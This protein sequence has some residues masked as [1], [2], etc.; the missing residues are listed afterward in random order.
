MI[1]QNHWVK[2]KYFRTMSKG[3]RE[4]GLTLVAGM[5]GVGKTVRSCKEIEAY[6][7]ND[8]R[9][10]RIGRKVLIFDVN[11]EP[12]YRK[13][14]TIDYDVEDKDANRRGHWIRTFAESSNVEAR[15]LV[16]FKK[17]GRPFE[18]K[19]FIVCIQDIASNFKKG[20]FVAEDINKYVSHKNQDEILGLLITLR[21]KNLDMII[22]LQ[23][24]SKV[25]TTMWE[26]T[27]Y[28]RMH[29]QSDT[30]DRYKNR[31]PNYQ[32]VKMAELIIDKRYLDG[33]K[34]NPVY[35]S[36]TDNIFYNVTEQEFEYACNRYIFDYD[37][38]IKKLQRVEEGGKR[39]YPT[40]EDAIKAW[41][42]EKRFMIRPF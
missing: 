3:A 7:M 17:N 13:Y 37:G 22:H 16:P 14:L 27:N 34:Y 29:K 41:I 36:P 23:S 11:N 2:N 38:D 15:R 42:N 32:I 10:G 30:V 31:I 9:I 19:D 24:L 18:Y 28:L 12:D 35:C 25:T 20:L 6:I 39:K 26:N 40:R 4:S 1:F 8:P 21:H 5:K 33:D